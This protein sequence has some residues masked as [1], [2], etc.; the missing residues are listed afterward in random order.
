MKDFNE[1]EEKASQD[2]MNK[3]FRRLIGPCYIVNTPW[4]FRLLVSGLDAELSKGGGGKRLM[5]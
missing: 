4:Y 3:N 1:A 2:L 5:G